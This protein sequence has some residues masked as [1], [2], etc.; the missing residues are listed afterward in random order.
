MSLT[1]GR[2]PKAVAAAKSAS[3]AVICGQSAAKVEADDIELPFNGFSAMV[4]AD[5][6]SFLEEAE[7]VR[8]DFIQG[9]NKAHI[10]ALSYEDDMNRN[11]DAASWEKARVSANNWQVLNE[12]QFTAAPVQQRISAAT[13]PM[14]SLC[15][16]LGLFGFVAVAAGRGLKP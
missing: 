2:T 13:L 16:W 1:T 11:K 14:V 5:S 8:Y 9:L 3:P 7:T 6:K 15:L 10:E 12:Y 4:D